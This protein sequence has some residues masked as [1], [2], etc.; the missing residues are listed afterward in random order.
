[1][2][3]SF[4]W[5]QINSILFPLP[6]GNSNVNLI[7]M[8]QKRHTFLITYFYV[9]SFKPLPG[10]GPALDVY[11]TGRYEGTSASGDAKPNPSN[12]GQNNRGFADT[13]ENGKF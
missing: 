8:F 3:D 12:L 6:W 4:Y 10:W 1:M 13:A 7:Y 11:R 5:I 2:F 9:K